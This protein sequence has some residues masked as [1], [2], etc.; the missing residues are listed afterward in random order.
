VV[1]D[2]L[3]SKAQALFE[4]SVERLDARTRSKLTQARNRALDE[5]KQGAVRRRWIWA[6]VGGVALAAVAAV[7]MV[8]GGLRSSSEAGTLALEDI[9]IVA[10][11]ENLDMLEDVEFY[12]WLDAAADPHSG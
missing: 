2:E 6:P 9:D 8:S 5:A 7:V 1:S 4:D 10:D 12:Q 11:S 3:E